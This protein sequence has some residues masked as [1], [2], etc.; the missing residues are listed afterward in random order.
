MRKIKVSRAG[1]LLFALV[2]V[3]IIG[4]LLLNPKRALA[5]A[6]SSDADIKNAP[7]VFLD[8]SHIEATIGNTK[9]I[10]YDSNIDDA[11]YNYVIQGSE[12]D[13]VIEFIPNTAARGQTTARTLDDMIVRSGPN[14][15]ISATTVD[16]DFKQGG[17]GDCAPTDPNKLT[18]RSVS[19]SEVSV[20]FDWIDAGTIKRADNSDDWIFKLSTGSSAHPRLFVRTTGNG[21]CGDYMIV[22]EQKTT[23]K[24]FRLSSGDGND[25]L[26]DIASTADQDILRA[27]FPNSCEV[28]STQP[29]GGEDV[30]KNSEDK[31]VAPS[32]RLGGQENKA[33]AAGSATEGD[34]NGTGTTGGADL[35]NKS[36]PDFTDSPISWIG[37]SIIEEVTK[38]L[39]KL[40]SA[41][42]GLLTTGADETFNEK[43]K[44]AKFYVMWSA[45]R[46][47]ALGFLVII[48]LVMI[49]SQAIGVG[50]FD[51]Y[52]IKKILPR[53]VFA[54]IFLSLSWPLLK[55]FINLVDSAGLSIRAIIYAPFGGFGAVQDGF[56]ASFGSA[57]TGIVTI[58]AIGVGAH[59]GVAG[60][61]S[62]AITALLAIFVGFFV[63]VLREIVIILLMVS[64]P[65]AII[66]FILP[67]TE[68]VWKFW[69]ESF[70][71]ALMMFPLIMGLLALGHVFAFAT[72]SANAGDLVSQIVA[73]VA[74]FGPYLFL[75]KTLSFAGGVLST[76]GGMVND[77]S[78][79]LF[80]S[81]REKRGEI[82][83]SRLERAQRNALWNQEK[84]NPKTLRG[85]AVR[86]ANSLAGV[87][88]NSPWDTARI[89]AGTAGGKAIMSEISA[90]KY[91]QSVAMSEAMAKA[92]ITND[93][94]YQALAG[95]NKRV[96]DEV[97]E[98]RN[99]SDLQKAIKI[100]SEGDAQDR[101]GASQLQA[102]HSFLANAYQSDEYGRG[103]IQGAALLGWASQGFAGSD[104]IAAVANNL[105][106]Q[107][108]ASIANQA[109]FMGYKAG[110]FDQ[111]PTY[112]V[113]ADASG[114]FYSVYDRPDE[115]RKELQAKVSSG[116]IQ[117]G[118]TQHQELEQ[119]I[120][121]A[122]QDKID[123]T[124]KLL[125]TMKNYEIAGQKATFL[126]GTKDGMVT[127]ASMDDAELVAYTTRMQAEKGK[128][129]TP[130]DVT[131]M[132]EQRDSMREIIA[133]QAYGYSQGDIKTRAEFRDIFDKT[134][135]PDNVKD[136]LR[137]NADRGLQDRIVNPDGGPYGA[138][139]PE[140]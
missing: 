23:F 52:S 130:E 129:V 108:G 70:S 104:D 43:G 124:I 100:L 128:P 4:I 19:A 68:K 29:L 87:L 61:V 26:S 95:R 138:P 33:K 7:L 41:I 76:V 134:N 30:D 139:G 57:D 40:D 77:R 63:V 56:A 89:M 127:L 48:A 62:L 94:A 60:L 39:S 80:D 72:V 75:P 122:Q 1:G 113:Q 140:A 28:W 13:G 96:N 102:A 107:L 36:C 25:K 54:V 8:R 112:G 114:K 97:G 69:R 81:Q 79:G 125:G 42:V 88:T 58:G 16:I 65:I 133:Q 73:F 105:G 92:G 5:A 37:C 118:S 119:E 24:I 98:I 99:A 38:M 91:Q 53:M 93:R 6:P 50:I 55:I 18:N 83:K 11:K 49:F 10:F 90:K 135:M 120:A 44:G 137:K 86:R 32:F 46:Y 15:V 132:R 31:I 110:R 35:E 67:N 115:L 109:T 27:V 12:C 84:Y 17:V 3:S 103:S 106:G 82:R 21:S 74:Y 22:N 111:K 51:A 136:Q 71:K 78:K 126:K 85:R 101:V 2:F 117:A 59:L 131:S 64:A 9:Y 121:V 47:I 45:F 14:T 116:E 66:A 123:T 20:I 34:P